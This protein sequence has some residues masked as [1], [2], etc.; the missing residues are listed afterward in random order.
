[1]ACVIVLVVVV[2][3]VLVVL[4]VVLLLLPWRKKKFQKKLVP[5]NVSMDSL[6]PSHSNN[7]YC[8]T[9]PTLFLLYCPIVL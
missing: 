1:M 6:D 2:G 5:L 3:T 7:D 8:K 9:Q 4:A